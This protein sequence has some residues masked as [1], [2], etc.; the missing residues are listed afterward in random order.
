MFNG[1]EQWVP[2]PIASV[3]AAT[4]LQVF[5]ASAPRG[6]TGAYRRNGNLLQSTT[7]NVGTA[8]MDVSG[9]PV[10]VGAYSDGSNN[11]ISHFSG[12][13][14]E[15]I[16]V[17]ATLLAALER[18]KLEGYLAHKWGLTASLP[19]DHPYKVNVPTP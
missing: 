1:T 2:T 10:R 5:Y 11:P 18:Q 6:T 12:T 17:S 19:N 14:S 16:L 8:T 4:E 13:I 7:S 3:T 9:P 15:I